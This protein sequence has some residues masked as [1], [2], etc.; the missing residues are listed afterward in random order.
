MQALWTQAVVTSQFVSYGIVG[1]LSDVPQGW[2]GMIGIPIFAAVVLFFAL[3]F[4]PEPPQR[5]I[6]LG[7][8]HDSD[9]RKFYKRSFPSATDENIDEKMKAIRDSGHHTG[10]KTSPWKK[11]INTPQA[12]RKLFLACFLT[13]A[14]QFTGFNSL[15]FYSTTLLK[16]IGFQNAEVTAIPI[17]GANFLG[18]SLFIAAVRRVGRRKLTICTLPWIVS[19]ALPLLSQLPCS[20]M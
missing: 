20:D 15:M 18:T 17:A 13:V 19:F 7:Q 11:L 8:D 9:V 14:S 4:V 6:L 16:T 5:Q 10:P 2:R 1:G 3:F 12:R